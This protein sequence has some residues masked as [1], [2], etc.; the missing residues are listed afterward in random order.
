MVNRDI[1]ELLRRY[2]RALAKHGV[3]VP[4]VVVFGSQATGRT[5][6]WSD[7]D[8]LVVSP[9]F[10]R[11]RRLKDTLLLW[12]VAADIDSRI[13]PIACGE[14]QWTDD[15]SSAIIEIARREG[16]RIAAR[17]PRRRPTPRRRRR[18]AAV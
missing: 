11:P 15:D 1:V 10:D 6:E 4:F 18:T 16:E 7:I 3:T 17:S 12:E 2:A 5:H 8:L 13:E 14:R 9:L